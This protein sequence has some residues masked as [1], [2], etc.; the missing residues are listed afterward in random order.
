MM[1]QRLSENYLL[2]LTLMRNRERQLDKKGDK[3]VKGNKTW[4]RMKQSLT[5]EI[6][7][8]LHTAFR[9]LRN[10]ARPPYDEGQRIYK[11]DD[12][13]ENSGEGHRDLDSATLYCQVAIF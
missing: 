6:L 11:G 7:L 2:V 8:G 13:T 9:P 4:K 3:P 12:F 1:T 10:R 5:A